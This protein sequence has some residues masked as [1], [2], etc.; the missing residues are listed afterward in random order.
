MKPIAPIGAHCRINASMLIF[1]AAFLYFS[2]SERREVDRCDIPG[3]RE[4]FFSK[5]ISNGGCLSVGT[6]CTGRVPQEGIVAG[7]MQ[8]CLPAEAKDWHFRDAG[9]QLLKSLRTAK[10]SKLRHDSGHQQGV[11]LYNIGIGPCASANS[12]VDERQKRNSRSK[13][14]PLHKS[15]S[16]FLVMIR[17]TSCS[18]PFSLSRLDGAASAAADAVLV[19]LYSR[20][21]LDMNVSEEERP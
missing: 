10:H 20:A 12:R 6:I 16:M 8:C 18:S 19:S 11:F 15:S 5:R 3:R 9:C 4:G 1:R 7:R 14:S 13:L 17:V 21:V 2:V